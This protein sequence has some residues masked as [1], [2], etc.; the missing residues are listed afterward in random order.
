MISI[1]AVETEKR[2]SI[3][4]PLDLF[5]R[6]FSNGRLEY[7]DWYPEEIELYDGITVQLLSS[8]RTPFEK[9]EHAIHEVE[10]Q[11][12]HMPH[13][14]CISLTL[15]EQSTGADG[16]MC[17][18]L[19]MIDVREILDYMDVKFLI[20]AIVSLAWPESEITVTYGKGQESIWRVP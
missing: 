12:N 8:E 3:F 14:G 18:H 9:L 10:G 11:K 6:R 1:K 17:F 16:L 20:G 5:I 2:D 4:E 15:R 7:V 13:R 19:N